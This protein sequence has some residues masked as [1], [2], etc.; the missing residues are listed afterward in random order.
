VASR[1]AE[2][3]I[4]GSLFFIVMRLW[5]DLHWE[6]DLYFL[7]LL[8]AIDFLALSGYLRIIIHLATRER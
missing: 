5:V 4:M 8:I 3:E 2:E 6:Y 7:A 1:K